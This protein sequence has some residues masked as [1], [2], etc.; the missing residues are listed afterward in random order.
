MLKV[1]GAD[2]YIMVLAMVRKQCSNVFP[3]DS[4]TLDA[5]SPACQLTNLD[6]QENRQYQKNWIIN[7]QGKDFDYDITYLQFNFT[8][9]SLYL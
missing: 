2:N 5:S 3:L 6:F 8:N 7:R 1:F 4:R 9:S